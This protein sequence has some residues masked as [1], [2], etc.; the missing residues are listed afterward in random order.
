MHIRL[1]VAEAAALAGALLVLSLAPAPCSGQCQ[2]LDLLAELP[3]TVSDL[4]PL[5]A[6]RVN[7]IDAQFVVD[8]GAF[9]SFISAAAAAKL[10][11]RVI[12]APLEFVVEGVGGNAGMSVA[13]VDQFE[14][15]AMPIRHLQFIVGGDDSEQGVAGSIGQNVL[16]FAD[17]EYDLRHGVIRLMRP[18]EGCRDAPLAYWA[19]SQAYSVID[20]EWPRS[21]FPHTRGAAFVNGERVRALFDT[22]ANRSMLDL[23]AA[24]RAGVERGM[25]EVV[26]AG[27]VYGISGKAVKTW[28]APVASFKL[29][30]EEIRKTRIRIGEIG[31]GDDEMLIGAD[32]FL[33]HR[34]YVA[35]SQHKLYFTYNGGPVFKLESTPAKT[36]VKEPPPQAPR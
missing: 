23:R 29:G 1:R 26:E 35:N 19:G 27:D 36:D 21:D 5:V 4:R 17:V 10:N 22:G 13:I 28:V 8:S 34:I 24:R 15:A 3:V 2:G 11:L 20:L 32:F 14:L 6:S 25:P 12:P 9:Y 33:S 18:R 7:G 31:I 16:R 30:D